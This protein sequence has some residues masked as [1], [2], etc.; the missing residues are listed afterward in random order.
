MDFHWP[1]WAELA[2]LVLHR[3]CLGLRLDPFSFGI[4]FK[5]FGLGSQ[6]F[7]VFG[8]EC[9]AVRNNPLPS[10]VMQTDPNIHALERQGGHFL[11]TGL[12]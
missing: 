8:V 4:G 2:V 7:C 6:G 9:R 12:H 5:D 3:L 10:V 11:I 1:S